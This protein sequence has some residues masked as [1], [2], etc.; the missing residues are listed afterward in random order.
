MA[1]ISSELVFFQVFC[2]K[3][4]ES[5]TCVNPVKPRSRS[6]SLVVKHCWG[7]RGRTSP[8]RLR[9]MEAVWRTDLGARG[10]SLLAGGSAG[11]GSKS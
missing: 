3:R 8:L 1:K 6:A 5:G 11:L 4:G 7:S 10:V 9:P 2:P